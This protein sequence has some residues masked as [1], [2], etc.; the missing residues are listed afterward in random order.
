MRAGK[1][2]HKVTLLSPTHDTSGLGDTVT[3]NTVT[4]VWAS[5][6]PAA[7]SEMFRQGQISAEISHIISMRYRRDIK[8]SWRISFKG[9]TF[10][11][12]SVIDTGE[13][14]RE[15]VITATEGL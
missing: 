15:L 4:T 6:E 12:K 2:K 13:A 9:R 3:W 10:L 14:E 5:I 1:Y 8:P 11:L 7:G